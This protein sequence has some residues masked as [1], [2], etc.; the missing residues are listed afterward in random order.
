MT[1]AHALHRPIVAFACAATCALAA[2]Q[3][4]DVQV[5]KR[6]DLVVVDVHATAA[7]EP[8]VAW[9]VLTDY[10]HMARYVSAVKS[11]SVRHLGPHTLEVD[12]VVET[13]VAFMNIKVSSVR[14]VELTP[15]REVRS[16][17]LRA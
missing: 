16:R 8:H 12:Q 4:I 17:L 9:A 1:I 3:P 10:E 14:S 2:G 5:D 15:P 6:G 13:R 11:S 7:I